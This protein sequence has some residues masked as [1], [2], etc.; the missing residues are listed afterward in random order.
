MGTLLRVALVALVG[1]VA[2]GCSGDSDASA[3]G[4]CPV[5]LANGNMP[6]ERGWN[7]GNG[8]LWTYFWPHNVVVATAGFIQADGSVRMKWPWWR[9]V[10]GELKIEGRRLDAEAPSVRVEIPDAY[11]RSGFQPT[12]IFFPTD[13]CWEVTGIVGEARLTFVTLVVKRA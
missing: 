10:R 12:A 8:E 13:G 11:G 4:V 3:D 1:L 9:G 5:T 2:V 6:R 7:H